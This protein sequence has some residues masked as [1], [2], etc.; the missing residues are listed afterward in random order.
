MIHM[1]YAAEFLAYKVVRSTGNAPHAQ[2]L[3]KDGWVSRK[4]GEQLVFDETMLW[5]RDDLEALVTEASQLGIR[6][7]EASFT[8]GKLQATQ[9]HLEDMRSLVFDGK[10]SRRSPK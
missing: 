9:A 5:D 7:K 6:P 10:T 2:Y 1:Q 8:E 4:P 3:T